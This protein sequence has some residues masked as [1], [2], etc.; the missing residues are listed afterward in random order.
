MFTLLFQATNVYAQAAT[1]P[2]GAMG[3]LNMLMPFV[4]IIVIFYFLM[5]RPQQKQRKQHQQFLAGL[6]KGDEVLTSSG[7]VGTIYSVSDKLVT[8]E[9]EGDVKI[10]MLKGMITANAKDLVKE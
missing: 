1:A 2:K 7:I 9:L 3:I 5:I 6:K 8:L 4:L 10:K